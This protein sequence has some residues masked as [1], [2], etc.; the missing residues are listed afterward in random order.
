MATLMK[1]SETELGSVGRNRALW[2][3]NAA[4][5]ALESSWN[6]QWIDST[7]AEAALVTF[8]SFTILNV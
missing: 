5:R 8:G 1:S 2:L 4:Q 6:T 7:L 3:R